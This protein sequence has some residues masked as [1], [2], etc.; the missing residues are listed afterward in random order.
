MNVFSH[1]LPHSAQL[2]RFSALQFN[3][4]ASGHLNHKPFYQYMPLL[5]AGFD[6]INGFAALLTGLSGVAAAPAADIDPA[7]CSA[8]CG[9][10]HDELRL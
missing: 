8:R 5:A 7:L 1:C 6:P 10:L 3:N 2:F 4:E 9:I